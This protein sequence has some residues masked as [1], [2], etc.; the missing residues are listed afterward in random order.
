VLRGPA[1][2]NPETLLDI[3]PTF[4]V[5]EGERESQKKKH[6]RNQK[7]VEKQKWEKTG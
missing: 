5:K 7:K 1:N 6:K 4:K 2:P 3:V